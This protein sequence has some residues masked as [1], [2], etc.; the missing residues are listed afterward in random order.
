MVSDGCGDCAKRLPAK[1]ETPTKMQT[2]R[3]VMKLNLRG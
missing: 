3:A 1:T 2:K